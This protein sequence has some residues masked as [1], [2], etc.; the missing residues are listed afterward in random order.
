MFVRAPRGNNS[1]TPDYVLFARVAVV[2]P[3]RFPPLPSMSPRVHLLF[4]MFFLAVLSEL[5][6]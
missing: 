6:R 5:L 3:A 2:F 4:L 1:F